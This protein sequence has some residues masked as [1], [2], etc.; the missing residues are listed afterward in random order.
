M[1]DIIDAADK[2]ALDEIERYGKPDRVLY[3]LPNTHGERLADEMGA[4]IDIL[5][6][7]TRLMDIKLGEAAKLGKIEE[8][9]K[10]SVEAA[11]K[12]LDDFD[13][14]EEVRDK[15]INCVEAHHGGPYRCIEAEVC[16]NADCYKFLDLKGFMLFF[17]VLSKNMDFEKALKQTESKANEKYSIL[18]LDICKKELEDNYRIITKLIEGAMV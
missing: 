10:M 3:D 11:K 17:H 14:N 7:G 18:S 1:K 12:F 6:I 2:F 13:I 8:H 15:I 9:V 5:R 4:D 16:A